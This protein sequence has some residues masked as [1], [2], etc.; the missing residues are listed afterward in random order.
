[1]DADNIRMLLLTTIGPK[2]YHSNCVKG[3]IVMPT[4]PKRDVI[5]F[6]WRHH[7]YLKASHTDIIKK[8][9]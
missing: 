5:K 2:R 9:L 8:H 4:S 3:L 1:M 6:Q 7:W